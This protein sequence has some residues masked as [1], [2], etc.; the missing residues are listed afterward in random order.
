MRSSPTDGGLVAYI[1]LVCQIAGALLLATLFLLLRVHAR[2][3]PY[4]RVWG[5]AWLAATAALA[6]VATV[7]LAPGTAHVAPLRA[8]FFLYQFFKLLFVGLLL[9]GTL[10]FVRGVRMRRH[11]GRLLLASAAYAALSAALSPDL[12]RV[13]IWHA[14]PAAAAFVVCAVALLRLP[15]SRATLGTRA[16]GVFF[17]MLGA[18]WALYA[19]AFSGV[20]GGVSGRTG[21][22]MRMLAF[23]NSYVDLLLQML[24][25]YGM[26][27]LLMEDAKRETDA[28]HAQLA[29]A[30]DQLR[31]LAL[32]D[33]LTGTL[34]RRAL[35]EGVGTE[36][37]RG[38]FGAVVMVDLDN[39]KVVNDT[40]G[41]AAGDDLLRRAADVLR[42]ATRP[43]DRLY[44]WGGDEF[45]L[46]LPGARGA[47]VLPRLESAL[48][49][50]DA[51]L[52]SGE[53]DRLRL[54]VSMGASDYAGAEELDD[55][56]RRADRAMYEVKARH[57]RGRM[58]ELPVETA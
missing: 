12:N 25:G 19:V 47:E 39:L 31:R 33:Q 51:E 6:A 45:L 43:S 5:A 22:A 32:Y 35:A 53:R 57:K 15:A 37:A 52:E 8:I 38:G 10:A 41:H 42:S 29:I 3:R 2:R 17:A 20:A 1:G 14:P 24:L 55:A 58:P 49:C 27:V 23:H 36:A 34:N 40:H 28:A 21:D 26:V 18:L 30:H 7:Y 44:R 9:G 46:V 11:L 13:V 54:L 50:A 4:F 16:T 48:A 56:V